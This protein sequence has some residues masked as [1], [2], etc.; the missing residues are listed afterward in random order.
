MNTKKNT[1][2]DDKTMTAYEKLTTGFLNISDKLTNINTEISMLE[3]EIMNL[4][5]VYT[6]Y[7][8]DCNDK[9]VEVN[10]DIKA[11]LE[12][13]EQKKLERLNLSNVKNDLKNNE[14][15]INLREQ[16]CNE[17]KASVEAIYETQKSLIAD[18]YKAYDIIIERKREINRLDNKIDDIRYKNSD[19]QQIWGKFVSN[20]N[21]IHNK[22]LIRTIA[23]L[24]QYD[25]DDYIKMQALNAIREKK[26]AKAVKKI[27]ES[28]KV[29]VKQEVEV[30]PDENMQ[31]LQKQ[32]G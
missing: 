23:T 20:K 25:K 30:K 31:A 13:L 19:I 21:F 32:T 5:T 27:L 1:W 17:L 4:N 11:K 28:V 7:L 22:K 2:K 6:A 12:L 3:R 29:E 18:I 24:E 9:S 14:T 16:V 10:I 8:I 15:I 26:A